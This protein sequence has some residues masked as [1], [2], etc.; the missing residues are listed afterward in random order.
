RGGTAGMITTED[1]IE[2]IFG[3]VEDEF[4]AEPLA[5]VGAGQGRVVVPGALAV[6]DLNERYGLGLPEGEARTVGGLIL[7]TLGRP[8]TVGD[9]VTVAATALRVEQVDGHAVA[10]VSFAGGEPPPEEAR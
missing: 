7:D 9:E 8:P 4:D 2:E 6:A 1:L 5:M 3:E 10:R